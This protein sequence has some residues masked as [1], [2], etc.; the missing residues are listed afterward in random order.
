N[1]KTGTPTA[2]GVIFIP[3][4]LIVMILFSRQPETLIVVSAGILFGA[5]GLIDDISKIAKKNAAGLS[6]KRKLLLQFVFASIVVL[7]IQLYNPHTSMKIPFGGEIEFGFLYYI[8]SAIVLAGMS[9]A[10]N[11]SDGIDGL[12][13]SMFIFSLIPLF[14]LPLWQNGIIAPICGALA[15][16]LWHNWFPASVFMG[17]TGAL[18]LGGMLATVF[19][20]E[21]RE[22]FL[23]FF[24]VMFIIEMFSVILQVGSFKLFGRRIF[25]MSPIHH[26]F[27]LKGWKETKITFRFSLL[28]LTAAVVGLLAW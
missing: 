3:I 25:R 19:A 5:V 22:I 2:S 8:I 10:V 4:S 15:G 18:G 13:G 1:Y 17:D 9:N 12:A 7:M 27:E 28:A 24:G 23:I 16:F 14:A 26:H 6:G 11:L 21:G 20:I